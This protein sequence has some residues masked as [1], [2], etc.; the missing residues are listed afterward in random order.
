MILTKV[1]PYDARSLKKIGCELSHSWG[2]RGSKPKVWQMSHFF[3]S[4]LMAS[5][6][7]I[8]LW[9]IIKK[10]NLWRFLV[11][12]MFNFVFWWFF[13][14]PLQRVG[15]VHIKKKLHGTNEH[16]HLL[17]IM[18]LFPVCF[19]QIEVKFSIIWFTSRNRTMFYIKH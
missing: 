11:I 18:I 14:G 12:F 2:G 8:I 9:N 4:T 19:D 10:D 13:I 16:K 6:I 7:E 17:L 3:F 1:V 15:T 5:L